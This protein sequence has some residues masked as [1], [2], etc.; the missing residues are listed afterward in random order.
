MSYAVDKTTGIFLG[1][2][3]NRAKCTV[4]GVEGSSESADFWNWIET[5]A[6]VASLD[7]YHFSEG[8]YEEPDVPTNESNTDRRAVCILRDDTDAG[9]V[10]LQIPAPK[11]EIIEQT[12]EGERITM[13]FLALLAAELETL[14]GR[15]HTPLKGYVI[16]KK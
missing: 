16:Q 4:S 2:Y 14:T 7:T 6:S 8:H 1:Q 9:I 5:N 13:I 12:T 11:E 3:G 10:R 15:G